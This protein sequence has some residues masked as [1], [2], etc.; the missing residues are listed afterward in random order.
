MTIAMRALSPNLRIAGRW[1]AAWTVHSPL[2]IILAVQALVATLALHNTA[3]LD[4][5]LYSDAGM[6][7]DRSLMGGPPPSENFALYFSGHP[8]LY[9]VVA[10]ILSTHGGIELVRL[11]STVCMLVVTACVY[12]IALNCFDRASAVAAAML[13]AF[14]GTTLFLSHFATYDAPCLALLAVATVLAIKVSTASDPAIA[15]AIGPILLLAVGVKYVALIFVPAVVALMALRTFKYAGWKRM[16]LHV[17]LTLGA[18]AV[19]AVPLYSVINHDFLS[20]IFFTT[21]NRSVFIK[22]DPQDLM[23]IIVT[24]GG[25]LWLM[26]FLGLVLID[27]R[28]RL[29]ALGLVGVSFLA[30][31]YHVYTGEIVSLQKHVG[32]G[33]FFVAP[34]A[35]FAI[36][37][38]ASRSASVRL[39]RRWIATVVLS[40]IVFIAGINQAQWYFNSW[41]SSSSLINAMRTQVR[42]ATDRYLC[43]DVEVVR[44]SLDDITSPYQYSGM[45]Y[46][47]YTN[48]RGQD[49]T[50]K[51]AYTAAISE[52]HFDLIELSFGSY[53]GLAYELLPTIQGNQHYHL[54]AKI[55]YGDSYGPGY[56]YIWRKEAD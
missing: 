29:F 44:Y 55:P 15:V 6:Q 7:I 25:L 33:L 40:L 22:S 4:E 45:G 14:Q 2:A 30:P 42:P 43:E 53:A 24:L 37:R 52:G 8:Y 35:G 54:I 46:F 3:F 16:C 23:R 50:G 9:P 32:F 17:A 49:L 48:S 39:D 47:E 26:S 31:A 20:G 34:L 19:V 11:F 13:F 10:G 51:A 5:A 21:A 1:R 56:Y 41:P 18:M 28:E 36:S 12:W 38:L 27:S